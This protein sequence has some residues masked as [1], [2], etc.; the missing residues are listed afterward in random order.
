MAKQVHS[1]FASFLQ[2]SPFSD[3]TQKV[4]NN[5]LQ[6]HGFCILLG[7]VSRVL[8]DSF[9]MYAVKILRIL[10]YYDDIPNFNLCFLR[11]DF[12]NDSC[13]WILFIVYFFKWPDFENSVGVSFVL[14]FFIYFGFFF[15]FIFF[16]G[17]GGCFFALF[18][19]WFVFFLIE[20]MRSFVLWLI[21]DWRLRAYPLL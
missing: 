5:L 20:S 4:S 16:L 1:F 6:L 15:R 2:N 9:S 18:G 3:T 11:N 13:T 8:D 21:S 19:V 12:L 7:F 14:P 17:G 10:S